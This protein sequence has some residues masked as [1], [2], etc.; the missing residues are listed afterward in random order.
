MSEV[1]LLS[2]DESHPEGERAEFLHFASGEIR[3]FRVHQWDTCQL[4][5]NRMLWQFG[6]VDVFIGTRL[7]RVALED[8]TGNVR[9][10]WAGRFWSEPK[11]LAVEGELVGVLRRN[12]VEP[13]AKEKA[14]SV[15]LLGGGDR[16]GVHVPHQGEKRVGNEA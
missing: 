7:Y 5:F 6:C 4:R 11:L 15:L 10:V 12:T 8:G 13:V 3:A 2:V 14:E 16:D 9:A 1:K